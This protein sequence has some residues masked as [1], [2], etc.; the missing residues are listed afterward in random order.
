MATAATVGKWAITIDATALE[1]VL[2]VSGMGKTNDTI[3]VTNF[4]SPAGTKEYIPGLAEG[5]E[6]SID[7][8]YLSAGTGQLALQ[9]AVDAGSNVAVVMTYDTTAATFTFTASAVG[10]TIAP[11]TN[12]QNRIEFALKV[13][14][15][16]TI[17]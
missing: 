1:E 3:E 10:W 13:S 11:S 9:T 14:G 15:D 8:N 5:S 17:T 12:D 4:D 7:C 6:I 2:S 16:I